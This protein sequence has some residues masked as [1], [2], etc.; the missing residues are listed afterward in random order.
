MARRISQQTFD[1]VV[2]EN[3]EEFEMEKDEAVKEAIAQFRKQGIDLSNIDLTGGEGRQQL[4][5]AIATVQNTSIRTA[6]AAQLGTLLSA[7][8]EIGA[9]CDKSHACSRRNLLIMEEEGG[10]NALQWHLDP[11]EHTTVVAQV[12]K[13]L[14]DLSF[15]QDYTRDLFEP[16]GSLKLVTLLSSLASATGESDTPN[17]DKLAVLADALALA[18]VVSRSENNKSK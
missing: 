16:G 8:Q 13:V 5:D 1:D 15:Q 11:N 4:L 7:V 2:K 10:F 18:K 3:I 17:D 14:A 6:D 9:V 12:L